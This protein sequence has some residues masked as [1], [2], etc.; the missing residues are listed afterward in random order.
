M[1]RSRALKRLALFAFGVCAIAIS[2]LLLSSSAAGATALEVCN[3]TEYTAHVAVAFSVAG[4][5]NIISKGWYTVEAGDCQIM[6]GYLL[7]LGLNRNYYLYATSRGGHWG[8]TKRLC[9]DPSNAFSIEHADGNCSGAGF[10]S[11]RFKH[12]FMPSSGDFTWTLTE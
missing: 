11:V 3:E 12:I 5:S 9:Y 2:T 10:D 1:P 8:G 6:V 7:E 4:T